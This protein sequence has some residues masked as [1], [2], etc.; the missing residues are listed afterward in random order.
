M[1]RANLSSLM[2]ME[3][4]YNREVEKNALLEQEVQLKNDLEIEVQRLKDELRGKPH[5]PSVRCC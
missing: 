4:K 3:L 1:N 5:I 2:D